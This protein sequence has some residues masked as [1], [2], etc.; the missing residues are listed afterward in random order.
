LL[1]SP[2]PGFALLT[3]DRYRTL[4]I[5]LA[6]ATRHHRDVRLAPDP[7]GVGD[8]ADRTTESLRS[9][10]CGGGLLNGPS[11]VDII[12]RFSLRWTA[13]RRKVGSMR[14]EVYLWHIA[15]E[16]TSRDIEGNRILVRVQDASCVE[17]YIK[18]CG[19]NKVAMPLLDRYSRPLRR[20]FLREE[21]FG[22]LMYDTTTGVIYRLDKDA[23][24]VVRRLRAEDDLDDLQ[25]APLPDTVAKLAKRYKVK[26]QELRE[27]LDEMG[28]FGL[29]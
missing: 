14:I 17:G 18:N 7:V 5:Q 28:I 8:V 21:S 19:C 11:A 15:Q 10:Y 29:W 26:D 23:F 25:R 22:G 12:V 13:V 4:T 6:R 2:V 16:V 27:L 9:P 3:V 1:D 24:S 20:A